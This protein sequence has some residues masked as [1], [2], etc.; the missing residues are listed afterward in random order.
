MPKINGSRDEPF[1]LA[2]FGKEKKRMYSDVQRRLKGLEQR[3]A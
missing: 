3:S 2:N 1:I